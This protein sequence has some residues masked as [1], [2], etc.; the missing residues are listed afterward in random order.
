VAFVHR[1]D[2]TTL[3]G[4]VHA[5]LEAEDLPLDL[6]P[7]DALPGRHQ[8]L[9]LLCIGSEPRTHHFPLQHTGP[10]S[11]YPGCYPRPWR[12]R[13]SCSPVAYGGHLRG[14]V[15]AAPRATGGSSVP[16]CHCSPP[17]DDAVHRVSGQCTPV[18]CSGCRRRILC[19]FDS[20]ASASCAG[21]RSRWLH[22]TFACAVQRCV[23][24]GIPRSRLP[25]SAVSPRFRP[26]RTSRGPGGYAVTPA[27][28]GRDLHPYGKLSYKVNNHLAVSL[29][30]LA[31]FRPTGRTE[32]CG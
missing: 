26:L 5:L 23:R 31:S 22:R 11:A 28:G 13:A 29:E 21:F 18:N 9:L 7:G 12:L 16:S 3:R 24:D 30:A 2:I 6:L 15:T 32:A 25:G 20:S 17:E 4:V 19:Q 1:S 8:G 14:E 27:P 10:T